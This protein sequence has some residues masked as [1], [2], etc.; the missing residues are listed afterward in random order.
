MG[1]FERIDSILNWSELM[2]NFYYIYIFFIFLFFIIFFFQSCIG[3]EEYQILLMI[4]RRNES[5]RIFLNTFLR[6]TYFRTMTSF[7]LFVCLLLLLLL[8]I[9]ITPIIVL[10]RRRANDIKLLIS[11]THPDLVYDVTSTECQTQTAANR[12]SKDVTRI[13]QQRPESP[14]VTFI[15]PASK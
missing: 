1:F 12:E 7:F 3:I 5:F 15:W 9:L 2:P 6:M 4:Y 8:I 14:S 13:Q 10:Y 11:H